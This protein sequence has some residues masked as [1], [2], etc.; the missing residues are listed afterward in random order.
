MKKLFFT[1]ILSILCAGFFSGCSEQ[2]QEMN[3]RRTD[4][5]L[6][7]FKLIKQDQHE[8]ACVKIKKLRELEPTHTHLPVLEETE[9]NNDELAKATKLLYT[10]EKQAEAID[11]LKKMIAKQTHS[12][13]KAN[14]IAVKLQDVIR[15]EELTEIII[16]PKPE[17][18]TEKGYRSAS[19]VL[20]DAIAEFIRITQKW[21]I[22]PSLRNK[23]I[24]RLAKVSILKKEEHE[25]E[26]QSLQLL[27]RGLRE[28]SYQTMI[29][30]SQYAELD[31]NKK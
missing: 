28:D 13:Q 30:V 2:P 20:R 21:N 7:I 14:A 9:K 18:S 19:K 6:E 5:I 3:T 16:F 27:A 15:L 8:E 11:M 4:L 24:Q 29:A 1:F 23:V 12:Q 22:S 31:G 10:K 25:R 26:I 17:F